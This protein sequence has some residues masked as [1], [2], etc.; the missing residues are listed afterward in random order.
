MD[1]MHRAVKA[2]IQG[3]NTIK[4]VRFTQD[5][6]PDYIDVDPKDLPYD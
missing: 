1:G 5:P 2:Y 6:A 4:A 3:H